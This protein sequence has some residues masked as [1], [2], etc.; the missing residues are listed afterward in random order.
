MIWSYVLL[1]LAVAAGTTIFLLQAVPRVEVRMRLVFPLVVLMFTA[2]VGFL[3][4]V[5][6]WI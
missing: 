2:G 1:G 5:P 6:K 4:V 3:L